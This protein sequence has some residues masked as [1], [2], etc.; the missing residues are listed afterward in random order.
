MELTDQAIAKFMLQMINRESDIG[1][2]QQLCQAMEEAVEGLK[3]AGL[4]FTNG[5]LCTASATM[6]AALAPMEEG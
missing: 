3:A 6:V 5:D 1:R 2:V 4:D